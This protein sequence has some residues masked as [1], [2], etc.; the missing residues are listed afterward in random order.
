MSY[1]FY[2][3]EHADVPAVTDEFK[4]IRNP[5]EL[6]DALSGIWCA[7]T[8]APRMRRNWNEDDRTLGQCSITAFLAQ[9]IFGGKVFGVKT[10]NGNIHCYNVVGG[11]VFDLTSEQFPDTQLCYEGNP[12]QFREKH[13][14]KIE[15][16]ERYVYL[17]E[18][19][20]SVCSAKNLSASSASDPEKEPASGSTGGAIDFRSGE[21]RRKTK[22]IYEKY[23]FRSV[24]PEEADIAADIEKI[25]FPPNE[26]CTRE[27]IRERIQ[28]APDLF[29]VVIEKKTGKMAGFLNGFSTK[30]E[31]FRDEFFLDASLYDPA[32]KNVMLFGLDVLPQYRGEGL[33]RELIRVYCHREHEN[34]RKRLVLTCLDSKIEMYQRFGFHD[35]GKADSTWGGEEWHE[36][37]IPLGTAKQQVT[38][39]AF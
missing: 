1:A 22:A 25:C 39:P 20:R 6:Y 35:L 37:E 29:L 19:L 8:C 18:E 3:W 9:D 24:R 13:F 12:E 32:G 2:G 30:E 15:K 36:M 16:W 14:E 10:E 11:C 38:G 17:K 34:G 7:F 27:K 23:E 33:G 5:R 31:K 4:G 28:A 26:A 21:L